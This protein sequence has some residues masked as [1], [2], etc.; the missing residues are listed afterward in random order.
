M[1]ELMPA[2]VNS[3]KFKEIERETKIPL[4]RR[5]GRKPKT[6]KNSVLGNNHFIGF[7]GFVIALYRNFPLFA[8]GKPGPGFFFYRPGY[9]D[10]PQGSVG[11]HALAQVYRGASVM[12]PPERLSALFPIPR[13]KAHKAGEGGLKCH[14]FVAS[15]SSLLYK[16]D[17]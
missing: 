13:L 15:I 3:R 9:Q 1:S 10:A 5:P 17:E 4:P 11:F 8:K 14:N 7:Y 6:T 16:N 2:P 12:P